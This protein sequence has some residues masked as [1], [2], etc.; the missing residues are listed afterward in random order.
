MRSQH[1]L[2]SPKPTRTNLAL[3]ASD[4]AFAKKHTFITKEYIPF[5][6]IFNGTQEEKYFFPESEKRVPG[7]MAQNLEQHRLFDEGLDTLEAYFKQVQKDPSVYD[8]N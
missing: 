3:P 2:I 1:K 6:S 5:K 4:F 7:S 8:G